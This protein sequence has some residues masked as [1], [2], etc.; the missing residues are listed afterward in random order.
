VT[1]R[2]VAEGAPEEV[3]EVEHSFTGQYLR[4]KLGKPALKA[5]AVSK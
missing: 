5:A 1:D 2:I 3:A 4:V